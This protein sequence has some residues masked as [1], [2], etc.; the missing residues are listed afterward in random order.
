M[1]RLNIEVVRGAS[2]EFTATLTKSDG[3]AIDGATIDEVW[4]TGKKAIT[5]A[6]G[7]A[8]FQVKKST[9]GITLV[10]NV[11]TVKV[12]DVASA[13]LNKALVLAC[14]LKVKFNDGFEAVVARGNVQVL[15]A[16][17]QSG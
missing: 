1:E 4:F 15:E 2:I 8:V 14:D 9:N 10:G 16:V 13:Q 5:D 7:A 12:A 3:S 11:L 17:T 6:D